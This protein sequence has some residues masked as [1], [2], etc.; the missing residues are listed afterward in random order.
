MAQISRSAP[1]GRLRATRGESKGS[2]RYLNAAVERREAGVSLS[3]LESTV[4]SAA[5]TV[6][7]ILLASSLTAGG[8]SSVTL[9]WKIEGTFSNAVAVEDAVMAAG[10]RL[11]AVSGAP[12]YCANLSTM[13]TAAGLNALSSLMG[14]READ[15]CALVSEEE[16]EDAATRSVCRQE[17]THKLTQK[18]ADDVRQN[19]S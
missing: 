19:C 5:T 3:S 16:A 7:L 9:R 17:N 13:L 8:A 15:A 2:K 1:S 12:A 4:F 18:E 11:E 10:T 6:S 14:R